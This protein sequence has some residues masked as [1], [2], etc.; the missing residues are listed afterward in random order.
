MKLKTIIFLSIWV[1]LSV[2]YLP[3][4]EA[5]W[6]WTPETNRF[7]NPKNEP[8]GSPEE[9]FDWAMSFYEAKEYKDALKEFRK[10]VKHYSRSVQASQSL[11]HAGE[12]LEKLGSY[13]K[14]FE[15]YQRIIDEY[16]GSQI[17]GE[18]LQRQFKIGGLLLE[19]KEKK[20]LGVQWS[21]FLA[22]DRARE[23]Y[24]QIIANAPYGDYAD[25]AQFK[26]GFS[27]E[28]DR[29]YDEAVAEYK[30]LL[31]EYPESELADQANYRIGLCSYMYSL[32]SDYD[33]KATVEAKKNFE[34]FVKRHPNS[35]LK[36]EVQK[37][38]K[39]LSEKEACKIFDTALF[40]EQQDKLE[41][42][43]IYYQEVKDRYP[44]TK[45]AAKAAKKAV[46][47]ERTIKETE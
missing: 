29:C 22:G 15:E 27:F 12:C 43:L 36:A 25:D 45:W 19:G 21:A 7:I 5:Y 17:I 26:L 13:Y 41:A 3:L 30:K 37:N 33:D 1:V 9:Q 47:I 20:I 24:R 8:K 40:Y 6:I 10:L 34:S 42:A 38:L 28:H 14:A 4:T 46:R 23:I 16:P 31:K 44:G 32:P 11:Y 39:Q 18:V 35:P 2:V